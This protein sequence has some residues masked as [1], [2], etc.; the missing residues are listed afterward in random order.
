MYK[1]LSHTLP[2]GCFSLRVT[3]GIRNREQWEEPGSWKFHIHIFI[4]PGF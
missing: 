1:V 3:G 4:D 2:P